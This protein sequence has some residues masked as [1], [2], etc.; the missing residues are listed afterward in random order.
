[1][2]PN[3]VLFDVDNTLASMDHRIPLLNRDEPDWDAFEDQAYLDTPIWPTIRMA[4]ACKHSGLQVWIWTG[5]TDRIREMT[6]QWLNDNKVPFDQ[7]LMRTKEQ[8]EAGPAEHWKLQTLLNVVPGGRV[9][10]AYDDD[11]NVVR[12]LREHGHILVY[13]VKRPT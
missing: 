9:I 10:C 11:P 5:R 1:M 6:T 4:Q 13:Q 2:T 3:I 12:V 7:L 8:A